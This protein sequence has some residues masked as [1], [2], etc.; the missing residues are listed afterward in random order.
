MHPTDQ[1]EIIDGERAVEHVLGHTRDEVLA[2]VNLV[3]PLPRS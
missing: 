2:Q 3:Q 1:R